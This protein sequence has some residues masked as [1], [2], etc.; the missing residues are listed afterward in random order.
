MTPTIKPNA[1]S[2]FHRDGTVSYWNIY[3]QRWV[4]RAA[5]DITATVL[6]T[7][8]DKERARVERAAA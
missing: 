8:S 4:R 7:F 6:A 1:A 5:A 2:T 3:Q